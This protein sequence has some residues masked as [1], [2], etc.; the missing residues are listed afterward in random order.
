MAAEY[1]KYI[2]YLNTVKKDVY[3]F[4]HV[5]YSVYSLQNVG[6]LTEGI[7]DHN[8]TNKRN[9]VKPVYSG[10]LRF[11]RKVSAISRCPLYTR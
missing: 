3:F 5:M 4:H 2:I 11:L 1:F 10:H 7:S 6:I 8:D 9:T